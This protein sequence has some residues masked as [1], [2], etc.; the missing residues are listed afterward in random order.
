M[1]NHYSSEVV[2][3]H[4]VPIPLPHVGLPPFDLIEGLG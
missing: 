3:V 2:G 4:L 1:A